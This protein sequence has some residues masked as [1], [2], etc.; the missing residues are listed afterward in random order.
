MDQQSLVI[1]DEEFNERM[2]AA[3]LHV[4]NVESV[5]AAG[6]AAEIPQ[7]NSITA[8]QTMS[9]DQFKEEATKVYI[10]VK[11]KVK[12][13]ASKSIDYLGKLMNEAEA[14]IK[15]AMNSGSAS[16]TQNEHEQMMKNEDEFQLQLAMALSISEQEYRD[17]SLEKSADAEQ[18]VEIQDS[19]QQECDSKSSSTEPS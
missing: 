18:L 7:V 3:N 19:D 6:S 17:N 15:A 4:Q 16:P 1:S 2:E 13:G 14:K 10:S 9:Q 8:D 12:L 5:A 11:E